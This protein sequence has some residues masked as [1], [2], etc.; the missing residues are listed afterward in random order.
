MD[1]ILSTLKILVFGVEEIKKKLDDLNMEFL[2]DLIKEFDNI[3]VILTLFKDLKNDIDTFKNYIIGWRDYYFSMWRKMI[4]SI[5][6]FINFLIS[7]DMLILYQNII[8][9]VLDVVYAFGAILFLI[10]F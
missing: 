9:K 1:I 3:K 10:L 7:R 6:D 4:D 5:K 2:K 8:Y